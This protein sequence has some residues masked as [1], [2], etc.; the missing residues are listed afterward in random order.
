MVTRRDALRVGGLAVLGLGLAACS[1]GQGGTQPSQAPVAA[2][3]PGPPRTVRRPEDSGAVGDGRADDTAALQRALAALQPG[4]AL[5]LGEGRTYLH[6]DVLVVAVPGVRLQGAGTLLATRESRSSLKVLADDVEVQDVTLAVRSTSRRWDAP[7]QHRLYVGPH[8]GTALRRV[9]VT[10]SAAAGVFL[11]GASGFTLTE[12]EVADTRADGIHMTQ[13][14]H[15]GTVQSPRISRSGDDGVAVVSY[16]QDGAVCHDIAVTAPRVQTTTGGRGLSV[17][18]GED[19]SYSDI[20]VSAS[21][22]A[23]VYL[24]CEG[25]PYN[26]Y[27]TRRVTVRGGRVDRANT[28]ADIDHG[29]VLVYSGRSG[30]DVRDVEVSGLD[31]T[32]TRASASRQVGVIADAGPTSG[33]RL[34]DLTVAGSPEPFTST[35]AGLGTV[36]GWRVDGRARDVTS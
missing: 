24:A 14:S 36:T 9:H 1:S 16:L 13:G 2:P 11:A 29:A 25:E 7:D 4:E 32:A 31:L 19:V 23:G 8:R 26:T 3:P 12:V 35:P 15:D 22:A 5:E 34:S 28:D 17:V 27:P 33:V 10:G 30:G 6:A 18:G 21:A 20:D